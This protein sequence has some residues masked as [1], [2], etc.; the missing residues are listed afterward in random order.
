MGKQSSLLISESK[1][2]LLNLK[3]Q[4]KS[5]YA[6]QR[7]QVLLLLKENSF[8]N[9]SE[10]ALAL[11]KSLRTIDRWVKAYKDSGITD[12]LTSK[13]GGSRRSCMS[14]EAHQK[15][16]EKL[17]DAKTP[18]RGYWD[19]VDWLK[20]HTGEKVCYTT[21]R[22][23]MITNFKTKLKWPRKSHYKKDQQAI[24]AFKKTS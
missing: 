17:Q 14:L 22:N 10:V 6:Q 5:L 3:K 19:A 9:R 23:Y 18:L 16:A 21:L 4:H 2:D 20:E 24:E 12:L 1:E 7:L 11:G 13:A 15:L 8:K